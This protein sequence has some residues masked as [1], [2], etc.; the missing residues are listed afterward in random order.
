VGLYLLVVD[1]T[2]CKVTPVI[3]HGVVSPDP[4]PHEAVRVSGVS[5]L[6][7]HLARDGCFTLQG[8]LAHKKLTLPLGPP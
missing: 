1:V 2:V 3:L 6:Q 8:Y 5:Y 7:S 4:P